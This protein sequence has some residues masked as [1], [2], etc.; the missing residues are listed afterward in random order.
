MADLS[1]LIRV[2]K[3]A[4]EQK[5]KF[6]AELY[7]QAEELQSQRDNLLTTLA[8]ERKKS[9]ELGIEMLSYFGP[10]SKAVNER[11]DDIDEA[12][13]KLNARIEVAQ[14]SMREAFAEL[15]KI[16]ITQER[17]QA[18][19]KAAID[20]KESTILDETGLE[21]YRRTQET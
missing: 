12:M 6:L 8:A 15:K 1:S 19:E 7:R 4:V 18:E 21:T 3:H 17:R 10:Y 13:K 2:R 16:E 5:Q 9:D 20:K 11:V 14:D